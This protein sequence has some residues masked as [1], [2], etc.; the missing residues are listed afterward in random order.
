MKNNILIVDDEAQIRNLLSTILEKAG[1]DCQTAADVGEAKQLLTESPYSLLLTDLDLPDESGGD[2]IR[3]C[4]QRY[5]DMAVVIASVLDDPK[6]VNELLDLDVY[7]YIV[8]PFTKNLALITVEN[9]LRRHRLELQAQLH[10]RLLER[11]VAIRTASLNEQLHFLQNLLDA[12]PAPIYYKDANFVYLGC[13][14]ACEA[15]FERPREEIIGKTAFDVHPPE[16]AAEYHQKDIE[17]F[18]TGG[19]QLYEREKILA[20]GSFRVGVIHKATFTDSAGAIA[21]LVA[22]GIDITDLKKTERWLRR[23]EETLRSIMDNLHIG[24]MMISPQMGVLQLNK[25]MRTWFPQ[26]LIEA[27]ASNLHDFIREQKQELAFADFSTWALFAHGKAQEATAKFRTADGERIFRI[28]V[29]PIFDDGGAIT[30]AVGL[31]E[32][33]TEKLLLER[34]LNQTQKLEA[35]GQLA[36]GIAHEIN[37]PVQYVGDNMRFLS[38]S[39]QE[40]TDICALNKQLCQALKNG[41]PTEELLSTLDTAICQHDLPFLLEEIPKTIDQSMDGINRV[42]AIVRAMREFSHPG[43]EE[44]VLVDIN[45]ALDNTLTVSRN[46]WKYLAKA[47]TD[48]APDLPMLRCLPGEINQVFL[49]IIVNAAHAIA[50]VTDGGRKGKGV[51]RLSTRIHNQWMVIRIGDTGGGIPAEVQHRIFEPFFTTKKIGKGTG[52]GL[53]LARNVVV[54]KHQGKLHF[55]TEPGVGATFVIQLPLS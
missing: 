30:A 5:P 41:E 29:N 54:D 42:G 47:E 6:K 20:D 21:G 9:S 24:V 7:G 8:K 12:I 14:R 27:D 52:Q 51:I 43:S 31:F 38:D 40:I 32:D 28:V 18:Q 16:F 48:F 3:H 2:L 39:F 22:I 26:S 10:T 36:A 45:H 23:S 13:N 33:I 17:I 1:Y 55:E 50:D 53:A 11:E 25:Q 35:I 49:N 37:T 46:E 4:K 19:F 15:I 44:K 34:E